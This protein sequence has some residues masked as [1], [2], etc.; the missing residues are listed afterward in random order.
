MDS[1]QQN[2]P[3]PG[4]DIVMDQY[5]EDSRKVDI[6]DI[7]GKIFIGGLSWQTTE[8]NLRYYFEKFGE[9]S[10]VALMIDKRS[11]KPRLV[12]LGT[13]YLLSKYRCCNVSVLITIQGIRIYKDEGPCG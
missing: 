1:N 13:H 4:D 5:G 9:L 11:G 2:Q 7:Q 6:D 12:F 10:D 8:A 3:G